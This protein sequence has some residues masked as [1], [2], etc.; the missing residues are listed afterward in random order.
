MGGEEL[1]VATRN[2]QMT[3]KQEAPRSQ[4]VWHWL[5]YPTNGR[6]NLR[7]HIQRLDMV[8]SWGMGSPTHLKRLNPELLLSKGNTGTKSRAETEERPVSDCP[9]GIHPICSHQTQTLLLMTR[10]ACQQEP[11]I[12]VFWGFPRAL[13]IQIWMLTANHQ[14]AH[15]D[16]NGGVRGRIEGAE[17]ICNLH[18]APRD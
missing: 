3:R 13:P 5:K 15:G 10:S 8:S 6:E 12:A 17:R 2:S 18:K 7:D 1:G 9:L 4:Q 14:T 16:C 11:D